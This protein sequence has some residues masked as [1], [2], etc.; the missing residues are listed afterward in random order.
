MSETTI[1]GPGDLQTPIQAL[2]DRYVAEGKERGVQIA[3]YHRGKLVVD[4]W[5]G[6]ADAATARPVQGDT[7]FPIYSVTKGIAATLANLVVERGLIDYDTPIA[8]VW[9]EFAAKGK[10]AIT[11]GHAL[12]HT[13]GLSNMPSG[14]DHATLC[15]WDAMCRAIAQEEPLTP[16]GTKYAYHAITYS[17][18]VGEVVRRVDGRPFPQMLR[19]EIGVPLGAER[20]LFCGL[21]PSEDA[22]VAAL[23][24]DLLLGTL[25]PDPNPIP[26]LVQPLDAWMMRTDARRACVPGSNGIMTARGIARHYAALLPGGVDGVSLLPEERVRVATAAY[27]APGETLRQG[28]GYRDGG[29]TAES[30]G[31]AGYGGAMGFGDIGTGYALGFARNHF[32][33]HDPLKEIYAL[34]GKA[35]KKG[36]QNS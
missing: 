18:T 5:A 33:A 21:P 6:V 8:K 22:R 28:M 13:A 10:A 25:P 27:P 16:P 11:F 3:V 36:R 1:F 35:V 19:E 9:P 14:L 2:L 7:L 30:F 29:L 23:T 17:W 34:L 15:D 32:S 24:S 4:A 31:H 12:T 20:D 26:A